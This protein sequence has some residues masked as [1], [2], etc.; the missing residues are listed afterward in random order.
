M[1]RHKRVRS[2]LNEPVD[3]C[4]PSTEM[5][6]T[7]EQMYEQMK[8]WTESIFK[9]QNQT[10]KPS[11]QAKINTGLRNALQ[12]S[13]RLASAQ[14]DGASG[15]VPGLSITKVSA[16]S[17]KT[18]AFVDP[19]AA[20]S[21][22]SKSA[23]KED[24]LPYAEPISDA[25]REEVGDMV[26]CFG[27]KATRCLLSNAWAPRV[28]GL[29]FLQYQIETRLLSFDKKHGKDARPLVKSL[30]KVLLQALQ[31]RVNSVF[32]AGVALLMEV[33]INFN[34]AVDNTPDI[35][36]MHD[37]IRPLIPRLLVKLG[38][39]K[40]RL[41]VTTEDALLLLSRQF[42]SI[43]PEMLLEEMIASDRNASP[44]ALSATYLANKL[45][46]ISKLLLE[47]GVKE[48]AVSPDEQQH[49]LPIKNVLRP[50][51][52]A[53]EHRDQSVRQVA[54]QIIADAL[55]AARSAAMPLLDALARS[56][57]Q[58][59]ISRL[60]EKGA[61]EAD[62]LME[63]VD[64]F[65]VSS[66]ASASRPGTSGGIRPPTASRSS[67]KHRPTLSNASLSAGSGS[68]TGGGGGGQTSSSSP[69]PLPYGTALTTEQK[70]AFA[71]IIQGFGEEI[72]RC[73]LD[74]AWAQ[75]EAAVR[76]V[77]RQ[78][79]CCANGKTPAEQALPKSL[80]ILRNLA[81]V[82]EL[83]LNDTV[84][85]VF[86]CSLRLF[87]VIATDFLP[88]IT[89]SHEFV[90]EILENVV[91]L[92]L[93]KLGDTKQ[94]IRQDCFTLL[95]SMASLS[96]VG[97]AR[98]CKMLSEK[99]QQL[100]AS[101][102]SVASSAVIIGE[103]LKL[104]TILVKEAH[105]S[106][107]TTSAGAT[108]PTRPDM[109]FILSL[110]GPA[111]DNKHVDVRNAAVATYIVVFE[112]TSGGT[113]EAYGRV[114]LNGLLTQAKPA[115]HDAI[116][117]SIVQIKK[118]LPSGADEDGDG[119]N[120]T[121][122]EVD[123][124][125]RQPVAIDMYKL[126]AICSSEI[127]DLLTSSSSAQRCEGV[128]RLIAL[129]LASPQKPS[130]K[131]SWEICCLLTKQLLADS[132]PSVCLAAFD[133]LRL[134]VDPPGSGA[135]TAEFAIPWGEWGVHLVLGST[136]RSV[137]QQ[138]ASESVRVRSQVKSLLQLVAGRHSVGKNAVCNALLSA[139]EQRDSA[140][141]GGGNTQERKVEVAK[142]R[143]QFMLR[144]ELLHEYLVE[145]AR[146]E[147]AIATADLGRR[148]SSGSSASLSSFKQSADSLSVE[149]LVPF[150]GSAVAHPSPTV[151]VAAHRIM[152]HIKTTR[153]AE[154]AKFI[155]TG[156][157]PA[158]QKRVQLL[159]AEDFG[160]ASNPDH[161]DGNEG[162]NVVRGSRASHVRR[163]AALRPPRSVPV[164]EK[165]LM[166]DVFPPP[167]SAPGKS[168]RPSGANHQDQNDDDD[169]F[170]SKNANYVV[171]APRDRGAQGL[172]QQQQDEQQKLP[173]WLD[174]A[175][176]VPAA[177][178]SS[179]KGLLSFDGDSNSVVGGGTAGLMK[180]RRKS[181]VRNRG[182][183]GDDSDELLSSRQGVY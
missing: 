182:N 74:K 20:L 136:I 170:G 163:I 102:S 92:V 35:A 172:S 165:Q 113:D 21:P 82:L 173:I 143:W 88:L 73:L 138:A 169:V 44:Q 23:Q 142:L 105:A 154:V 183:N 58:K 125:R 137:V 16:S 12:Q 89:S 146:L 11:I 101:S 177:V 41:H 79:V 32:E 135:V 110:V 47:F 36:V 126:S 128:D 164:E 77:E 50:A 157:S 63:E 40:S 39:S 119:S 70:E 153:E 76:E 108:A 72:V 1:D 95:H 22:R 84:A 8:S 49:A 131:G 4:L 68:S 115:I 109:Q 65:E 94:R 103:L 37:F 67:T 171:T 69:A 133:L 57:R 29:S 64:D 130:L 114:D 71:T 48:G 28:E 26:A 45:G 159:L 141:G 152:Q 132:A 33:A 150:L 30:Q 160:G 147:D 116:S 66:E 7:A 162:S 43:G 124:A 178:S 117:R 148:R 80:D 83:G 62:M 3:R 81:H 54:L 112:V 97:H 17:D 46:L 24:E 134:L 100:A 99:Y 181:G 34:N 25:Q 180:M 90:D 75:R 107:T 42:A 51:L 52:Q 122:P 111:L 179:R 156:C 96:H 176:S 144:L 174:Q 78:V 27:E 56:S 93:Q 121:R 10:L 60:V 2:P 38:D 15:E 9:Q 98:M 129:F 13:K 139:P 91:G 104:L 59:L 155:Q 168:R 19:A 167:Q 175:S 166:A 149:N 14:T 55:Q 118:A 86:Q 161:L 123:S 106:S 53:C 120:T 85:R 18:N 140:A 145:A 127:T 61:L 151:R 31:D 5:T 6:G 158:L 87:Q